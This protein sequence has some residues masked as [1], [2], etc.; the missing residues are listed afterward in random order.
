VASASQTPYAAMS[1]NGISL[2]YRRLACDPSVSELVLLHEG[3]GGVASWRGFPKRLALATGR[4]AFVNSRAGY[5]GSDA[6]ALP[7]R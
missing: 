1:V 4:S 3:L 5:S 7:R 2:E 6:I